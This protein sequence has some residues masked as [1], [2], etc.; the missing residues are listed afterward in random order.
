[1]ELADEAGVSLGQVANVK[2]LLADREWIEVQ[3]AWFGPGTV[4]SAV[5]PLLVEWGA[6]Y[7]SSRNAVRE[8]YSLKS[9]PEI[10]ASLAEAGGS[11][12]ARVAFTGFSGAASFAA[13]VR[14]SRVTAYAARDVGAL[15]NRLSLNPVSSG[16]NTT[17][18]EPYNEGVF[19]RDARRGGCTHR[20]PPSRFT[21]I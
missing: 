11:P 16:A 20:F 3:P 12:A 13:A 4:E 8:F 2:K 5:L 1:V 17:L 19:L 6:N 18:L 21:S 10:E 9:I 15:A 14:Y 7:R